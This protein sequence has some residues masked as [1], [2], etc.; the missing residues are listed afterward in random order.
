MIISSSI[1]EI[2]FF[3]PACEVRVILKAASIYNISFSLYNIPVSVHSDFI[4]FLLKIILKMSID[5]ASLGIDP[6]EIEYLD[7]LEGNEN[8]FKKQAVSLYMHNDRPLPGKESLLFKWSSQ[9]QE[10]LWVLPLKK[11]RYLTC[12]S[13]NKTGLTFRLHSLEKSLRRWFSD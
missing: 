13:K 11:T 9:I 12:Y 5:F 10:K 6:N 8:S 2:N 4:Y 7:V 3:L 1:I